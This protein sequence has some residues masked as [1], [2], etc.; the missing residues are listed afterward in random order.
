MKRG[1]SSTGLRRACLLLA[2]WLLCGAVGP[3]DGTT[4][5][6]VYHYFY[7]DQPVGIELDATQIAIKTKPVAAAQ[8]FTAAAA[9]TDLAQSLTAHGFA[10]ADVR[11]HAVRGWALAKT[12]GPR[13]A[14]RGLFGAPNLAPHQETEALVGAVAADP[15]V[16]FVSPVFKDARGG[17]L[18]V[19]ASLLLGFKPHVPNEAR[20][21][22]LAAIDGLVGAEQHGRKL[23]NLKLDL[24]L[25]DG[26][27]VLE[28]ANT[29]SA[30]S[31]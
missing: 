4:P 24:N 28:L 20:L 17:A 14:A 29:A 8:G 10:A 1:Q 5:P 7:F 25:R 9:A 27:A 21:A 19:T 11:G 16:E 31:G 26:F 22:V 30:P 6:A 12:A 18:I 2:A 23:D 15:A 3:G 13:R